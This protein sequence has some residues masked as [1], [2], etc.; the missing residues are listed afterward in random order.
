MYLKIE[1]FK[2]GDKIKTKTSKIEI[3]DIENGIYT[4]K[5]N[6]NIEN[7][8]KNQLFNFLMND[9]NIFPMIIPSQME[10]QNEYSVKST[11]SC[12]PVSKNYPITD[13]LLP[14]Q[15][16]F[17]EHNRHLLITSNGR[18]KND[19]SR[20]QIRLTMNYN[21]DNM[22]KSFDNMPINMTEIYNKP[23]WEFLEREA[24]NNDLSVEDYKIEL[25]KPWNNIKNK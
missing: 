24:I 17:G 12:F 13:I 18:L 3:V 1:D 9:D 11:L 15:S 21:D 25:I 4:I 2:I 6:D 16:L 19:G 14:N 8:N 5:Y 10:I 23:R 20:C 7:L 22:I